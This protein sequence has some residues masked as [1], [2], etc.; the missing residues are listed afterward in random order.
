M[1]RTIHLTTICPRCMNPY[2][3][4]KNE[5]LET[6]TVQE[7]ETII[8]SYAF[9]TRQVCASAMTDAYDDGTKHSIPEFDRLGE[10]FCA[11]CI[12]RLR[13]HI[14]TLPAPL[15]PSVKR[16]T[17][18]LDWAPLPQSA[19]SPETPQTAVKST[20]SDIVKGGIDFLGFPIQDQEGFKPNIWI[21]VLDG[22]HIMALPNRVTNGKKTNSSIGYVSKNVC[23]KVWKPRTPITKTTRKSSEKAN[24]KIRI[25]ALSTITAASTGSLKG[26]LRDTAATTT[27]LAGKH[28]RSDKGTKKSGTKKLTKAGAKSVE[29]NK[30][31]RASIPRKAKGNL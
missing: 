2:T 12:S 31:T 9:E 27:K 21:D 23:K 16:C 22:N 6:V 26:I 20:T 7:P 28:V 13:L 15:S 17:T 8:C 18:Y 24:Q 1:C 14:D 25:A 5:Y 19:V 30:S 3:T 4:R 11:S 10:D 29:K